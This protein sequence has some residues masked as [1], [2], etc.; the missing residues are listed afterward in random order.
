MR[1]YLDDDSASAT[2]VRLLTQAGHDVQVPA[3]VDLTGSDDAVHFIH[4]IRDGRVVVTGNHRDFE[5]LHF[6]ILQSGG[7]HPGVL[8]V[9]RENNPRRDLTAR[10]VA[11]VVRNLMESSMSFRD[12]VLVANQWR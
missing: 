2:L 5:N 6:L 4:A 9:M 1:F 3:D 8:S 10:G 7:H 12:E 11:T